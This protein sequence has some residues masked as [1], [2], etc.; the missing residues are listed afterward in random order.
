VTGAAANLSKEQNQNGKGSEYMLARWL[1]EGFQDGPFHNIGAVGPSFRESTGP[2]LESKSI[3][4]SLQ[5]YNP[6]EGQ[7][8]Q[9]KHTSLLASINKRRG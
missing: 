9:N 6:Q 7:A 3:A 4:S 1:K 8:D 5:Y 2:C